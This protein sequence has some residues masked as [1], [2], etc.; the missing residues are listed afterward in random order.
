MYI[1]FRL[2]ISWIFAH[3][4]IRNIF[5]PLSTKKLI[6]PNVGSGWKGVIDVY[7]FGIRIA[8]FDSAAPWEFQIKTK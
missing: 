4:E 8:R 5:I 6:P 2:L 7:V 3:I 1:K